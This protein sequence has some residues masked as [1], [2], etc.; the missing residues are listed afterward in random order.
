ME[1][2]KI[3]HRREILVKDRTWE[4]GLV[5]VELEWGKKGVKSC[6]LLA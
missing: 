1:G 6:F 3:E 2:K 4:E 5:G